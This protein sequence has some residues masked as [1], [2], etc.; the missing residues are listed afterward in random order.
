MGT[1]NAGD[2]NMKTSVI[3]ALLFA[4]AALSGCVGEAR[5]AMPSDLGARSERLVIDGM[6]G[7]QHGAFTVGT[8][9][10]RFTRTSERLS[11]L[12]FAEDRG[13]GRFVLK[14]PEAGGTIAG[15]CAFDQ[16]SAEIGPVEVSID[17]LLY[18]CT[19]ER[20]GAPVGDLVL[21]PAGLSGQGRQGRLRFA[22][23][24]LQLRSIHQF[25][26]GKLPSGSPLGYRFEHGGRAIG[27]VD[28]NGGDKV[29]FA[30][31]EPDLRGAALAGALALSIFWDPA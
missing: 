13:G 2:R 17:R 14:G 6:G 26:G 18:R 7:W 20:D 1:E 30:P 12:G 8:S 21:E 22:G 11:G 10:G 3:V 28:L 25:E 15:S 24:E 9:S 19:F 5:I 16:S 31:R 29:L 4:G 27:A 23:R